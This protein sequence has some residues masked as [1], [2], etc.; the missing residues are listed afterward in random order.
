MRTGLARHAS[1]ALRIFAIA[2]A[3]ILALPVGAQPTVATLLKDGRVLLTSDPNFHLDIYDRDP[4]SLSERLIGWLSGDRPPRPEAAAGPQEML[5]AVL[6]DPATDGFSYTSAMAA[7]KLDYPSVV[8]SDGR[9]I[10]AGGQ[11]LAAKGPAPAPESFDPETGEFET[12]ESLRGFTAFCTPALLQDGKVLIVGG[13]SHAE[14]AVVYDP[15]TGRTKVVGRTLQPRTNPV[16]V[17]LNTGK[18]L[19]FGGESSIESPTTPS[20]E[21]Y[22]PKT[23][24][25]SS[26][27][28]FP[29][30]WIPYSATTLR[31]GRV[32]IVGGEGGNTEHSIIP[33]AGIEEIYDPVAGK[34]VPTLHTTVARWHPLNVM[35]K[36]GTVLLVGGYGKFKW[37]ATPRSLDTAEIYDPEDNTF[38]ETGGLPRDLADF[39]GN[40]NEKLTLLQNGKVLYTAFAIRHP[41]TAAL[42]DPL[43]R[44]FEAIE[45]MT[46]GAASGPVV[47]LRD[48]RVLL[49]SFGTAGGGSGFIRGQP[50]GTSATS[51]AQELNR[52]MEIFN[53]RNSL[54]ETIPVCLT[55]PASWTQTIRNALHIR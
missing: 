31:D 14:R 55:E 29:Y 10:F 44:N 34:L 15:A 49:V 27:G 32:F 23:E 2:F 12:I 41:Y 54:F 21:L 46:Y 4:R 8:L 25:F 13:W 17:L 3:A 33:P 50:T 5:H 38:R 16:T 18:V 52:T 35:L 20:A 19:I 26:A 51:M 43:S 28:N 1:R 6:F 53:P 9:V 11:T 36:D 42:Y 22:D 40:G 7:P 39:R 37:L 30:G 48:G 45:G 24:S 47:E